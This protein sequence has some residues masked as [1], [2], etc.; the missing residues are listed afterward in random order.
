MPDI[1]CTCAVVG[2]VFEKKYTLRFVFLQI[3]VDYIEPNIFSVD[4]GME[5]CNVE[6]DVQN[7]PTYLLTY[8]LHG[9]EPLLRSYL[10][11]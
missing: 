7:I 11:L 5:I 10:V 8:L 9:A 6:T 4:R 2:T 1:S 3:L